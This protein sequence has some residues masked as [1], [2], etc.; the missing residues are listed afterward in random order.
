MLLPLLA[1]CPKPFYVNPEGSWI[2]WFR[3]SKDFWA[4]LLLAGACVWA[5]CQRSTWTSCQETIEVPA[6]WPDLVPAQGKEDLRPTDFATQGSSQHE[7]EVRE[8]CT[9]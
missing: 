3:M 4:T 7:T 2:N 5:Y 1:A 8:P 9:T 6:G